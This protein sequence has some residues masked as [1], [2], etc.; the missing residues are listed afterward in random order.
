MNYRTPPQDY[1]NKLH[2]AQVP[3]LYQP[4]LTLRQRQSMIETAR[5]KLQPVLTSLEKEI[6]SSEARYAN[7]KGKLD[8]DAQARADRDNKPYTLLLQLAQELQSAIDKLDAASKAG[9]LLPEGVDF[10]SY[11]FG[12][13]AS[14]EWHLGEE[15]DMRRWETMV[16]L[17]QR[18]QAIEQE[19]APLRQR[20]EA[21][22]AQVQQQQKEVEALRDKIR[23][24]T[25]RG[26][27][28]N[29]ILIF[30]LL[31]LLLGGTGAVLVHFQSDARGYAALAAA[32]LLLLLIPLLVLRQRSAVRK[33]Q[34]QYQAAR[35]RFD[36]T[37]AEGK[38]TQLR[39][40]P[41]QEH[42]AEVE[43]EYKRLRRTF[44][45]AER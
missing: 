13:E 12:D 21:L 7:K 17:R 37:R 9:K 30:L 1:L 22:R 2:A 33:L 18:M 23:Q 16:T 39:W 28:R 25:R 41:V 38:K 36:Q 15:V 42:M 27:L 14:G 44:P 20:L 35:Q 31:A 4:S 24:R 34:G 45:Q 32:G 8:K 43:T 5:G 40:A 19:R 3:Q 6:K 10:G 11:I 29:R 26:V